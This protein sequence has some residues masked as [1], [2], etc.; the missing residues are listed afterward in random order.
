[1]PY[2]WGPNYIVPTDIV[3][4]YAGM[5]LLRE[6]Y[7]DDML[8]KELGELG[9]TGEIVNVLNPWYYRKKGT[10]TWIKIGESDNRA[11][12][13]SVRWDTADLPDGQYEIL[14][15]MHVTVNKEK[16]EYTIASQ[17]M[18]EVSVKNPHKKVLQWRPY[19]GIGN[20]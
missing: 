13:F 19:P 15:M 1:V 16:I 8:L 12:N 11:Q 6:D 3:K 5:V 14:G 9:L 20:N 4:V 17:N 2:K 7:D 18:V 10:P